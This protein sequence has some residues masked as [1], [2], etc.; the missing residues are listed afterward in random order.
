MSSAGYIVRFGEKLEPED[1]VILQAANITFKAL[2]QAEE[3]GIL[4]TYLSTLVGISSGGKQ[5]LRQEVKDYRRTGGTVDILDGETWKL[6]TSIVESD[7]TL[8]PNKTH[9]IQRCKRIWEAQLLSED[10]NI[11]IMT[12]SSTKIEQ[13]TI[14][15]VQQMQSL[16]HP[17]LIRYHGT[18]I[19][20]G[21]LCVVMDPLPINSLKLYLRRFS[22][23]EHISEIKKKSLSHQ[24]IS[25]LHYLHS[26]NVIHSN[27]S[28][29]NVLLIGNLHNQAWNIKLFDHGLPPIIPIENLKHSAPELLKTKT[30]TFFTD[31]WALGTT[32][33]ELFEMGKDPFH[34]IPIDAIHRHIKS[35]NKVPKEGENWPL[36]TYNIVKQCWHQSP[37]KRISLDLLLFFF[38]PIQIGRAHV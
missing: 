26:N 6:P 14:R 19:N 37:R 32:L 31:I 38:K 28:L 9:H 11:K 30:H 10:V 24:I 5:T 34:S 22:P 8:T 4:A 21:R 27:L 33:W 1:Q 29:K 16:S 36:N 2:V 15:S 20:K 18:T 17:H 3:Q 7:V 23:Y 25:A 13:E 12:P 35:K